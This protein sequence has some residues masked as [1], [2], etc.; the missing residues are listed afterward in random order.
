MRALRHVVATS[1]L[2]MCMTAPSPAQDIVILTGGTSGVYYPLG[3]AL[4]KIFERDLP[5]A[6]V[7]VIS[8]QATV[9]NLNLLQQGKGQLALA[10]GD[11]LTDAWKGNP[12]AGFPSSR[13]K[14]RL[15]GAAFPNYI[16]II[17][18]RDANIASVKDL[19]GKRVSVGAARSGNELNAR[20]LFDAAD[21]SY[22]DL[23]QVEY[24]AYGESVELMA[25]QQLDAAIISAGLGVA[26]VN[27]A[28]SQ[29]PIVF[30]PIQRDLIDKTRNMF[31]AAAIPANSYQTQ[32][33]DV[34]TAALNNFFVTTSDASEETVYR[35]TKAIFSNVK[36]LQ[37]VHPAARVISSEKA[38]VVRPIDIH[39]GAARYFR[40][41]NLLH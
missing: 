20:A 22:A 24:L 5:N 12:E 26:A 33:S 41:M 21:M 29:M 35:I 4:Q 19:R 37:A 14:I 11:I 23:L 9:E 16:H 30:V 27:Q 28:V 39:P 34:P 18:R 6:K 13:T 25:K 36:E 10:Q 8:T 31:F 1:L 2:V 3:L 15:I 38:L 7:S 32:T 17:A 40:E